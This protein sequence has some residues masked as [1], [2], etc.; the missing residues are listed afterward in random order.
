MRWLLT[1]DEFGADEA[2]R[3]GL[4]QEVVGRDDLLA[5]AVEL[6]NVI[7]AQAPL[8]V[9]ATIASAR[10]AFD[11][12]EDAAARRLLPDLQPILASDDAREGVQSFI[13]RRAA[14]FRGR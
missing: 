9:R 14:V 11:E 12:G 5:R 3:I 7:A 4:V 2:L 6:A 10:L 1:G 8:G 13:E